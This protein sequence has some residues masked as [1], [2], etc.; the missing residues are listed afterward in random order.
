[1][2]PDCLAHNAHSPLIIIIII[3]TVM[4]FNSWI[5][6][7][8]G[9]HVVMTGNYR[10]FRP[11]YQSLLQGSDRLSTNVG[12]HRATLREVTEERR[13][14]LHRGGIL[15]SCTFNGLRQGNDY[16][17]CGLLRCDADQFGIHLPNSR[18]HILRQTAVIVFQYSP[19]QEPH[20]EKHGSFSYTSIQF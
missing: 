13:S 2:I 12:I 8:Q 1:M 18:R 3:I 11:T 16:A 9:C 20:K 14:H 6:D 10:R 19:P 4:L 5:F 15:Q 17:N 7:F